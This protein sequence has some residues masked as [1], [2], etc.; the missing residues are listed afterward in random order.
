MHHVAHSLRALGFVL[1]FAALIPA[2]R[3]QTQAEQDF[4]RVLSAAVGVRIEGDEAA[5]A[6]AAQQAQAHLDRAAALV[7]ELPAARRAQAA[8]FVGVRRVQ[9]DW[10]HG[11]DQAVARAAARGREVRQAAIQA[12]VYRTYYRTQLLIL[13]WRAMDELEFRALLDD[14]AGDRAWVFAE[15]TL[16]AL[17]ETKG[18]LKYLLRILRADL[19]L[20]SDPTTA[21]EA[22]RKLGGELQDAG[23]AGARALRDECYSRLA[24]H[25]MESRD[26]RRA[27]LF[28]DFLPRELTRYPRAVI[29]Y[30]EGDFAFA[31]TEA[32]ELSAADP[33]YPHLLLWANSG[34]ARAWRG[35][36]DQRRAGIETALD[37]YRRATAAAPAGP[38][39]AA[40]ENGQGDCLLALG[41]LTRA[42]QV[43]RA[44]LDR[45]GATALPSVRVE[46]AECLKDLGRVF[47]GQQRW[48]RAREQYEQALAEVEALREEIPYDLLGITWL[49]SG[50]GLLEAVDGILRLGRR[51]E[52]DAFEVLAVVDRMKARGLLD[53]MSRPP[54][55]RDLESYRL[56]W[57][58]LL[59]SRDFGSLRRRQLTLDRLRRA[60]DDRGAAPVL[61]AEQIRGLLAELSDAVLL[62]FW[63]ENGLDDPRVLVLVAVA[64][65]APVLHELG[66]VPDL[67]RRARAARR[68]VVR[69][70][71]DPWLALDRLAEVLLPEAVRATL[72]PG[73]RVL[74][75]PEAAL[76]WIPFAALRVAREPLG[77]RCRLHEAPSLAVLA[78]LQQRRQEV[79][80]TMILDSV[81]ED[82]ELARVYGLPALAF[83]AEE[84]G[85]V[86]QAWPGALRLSGAS[87]TL[88]GLRAQREAQAGAGILHINCHALSDTRTPAGSLLLLADGAADMGSLAQL[89]LDGDLVVFS[90]CSSAGIHAQGG[91]G[92]KGLLWGALGAGAQGVVASLWPVNQQA[93][94]DLMAQFHVELSRLGDP[95]EAMR[96]ARRRLAAAPNYAHPAYWAG[97]SLCS[98]PGHRLR[99]APWWGPSWWWL[100]GPALLSLWWGLRRPRASSL[101]G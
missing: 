7:S 64:G 16:E 6:K 37:R 67:Q 80:F 76:G 74:I 5:R 72:R 97:F 49:E 77:Q 101:P 15:A 66:T 56:T 90:A 95:A 62:S 38:Q 33:S 93:T 82:P 60:A 30:R 92:L 40:A 99:A 84:A 20:D 69:A 27:R 13:L 52:V 39:R 1:S 28:L 79:D 44:A 91:E 34:E 35:P 53:W 24:W 65:Q 59:R 70:E 10:D 21:L 87:A 11:S 14:P 46:R 89:P 68:A 23:E 19:L 2:T 36:E 22:L 71:T 48:G 63:Q 57:R 86:A 73:R 83:G 12:G 85:L 58:Q 8:F 45:L 61:S 47:E 54:R 4:R 25:A 32:G 42:E 94:K 43:Y 96:L 88:T 29:A 51:G 3:A 98:I 100:L 41:Q 75:S 26:Y 9:V 31:E 78:R 55:P 18:G 50:P 17:Q 81:P